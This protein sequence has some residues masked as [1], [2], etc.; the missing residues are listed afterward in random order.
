MAIFYITFGQ[1][2]VH[3]IDGKTF[4]CDCVA[5]VEAAD[6]LHARNLF[7]P[8]FCFSYNEKGFDI[9]SMKFFPRGFIDI[10]AQ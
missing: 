10:E 1:D 3:R 9:T 4:D 6:E 7:M 5:R 2:H 8:K